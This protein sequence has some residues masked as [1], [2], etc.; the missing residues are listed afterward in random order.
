V[1]IASRWAGASIALAATLAAA[2]A[3][4]QMDR[5][6]AFYGE[7][8]NYESPQNFALELRI[9]P[10]YPDVDSDP[11]VTGDSGLGGQK[12]FAGIFGTSHRILVSGEFDW[13]ALRIPHVGTLGPGLGIGYTSFSGKAP[14]ANPQP[15]SP[16]VSGE[17]TSLELYPFY[18]VAV[19][20]ADGLW[21]DLGVPLIP[22][23]KLGLATTLWR[24]SNTLG[25]SNYNG[26]SGQGYTLG[27]QFA[28]G[29]AFNL[30]VFDEYAAKTF[31][32]SV[33]VNT[34]SIFAEWTDANLN[35]LWAQQDPLRVGGTYWTF[36]MVWEF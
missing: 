8:R 25:T 28:V 32:Q 23:A 5:Q 14:V 7:H 29:V 2:T 36:G 10:F 4:A 34:T 27:T 19:F 3:Q 30:N 11:S 35:G 31:D 21:K 9:S 12:P 20:R 18:L 15:G 22:Y 24:A 1:S 33:G 13:Q 26:N 6:P 17:T 16:A